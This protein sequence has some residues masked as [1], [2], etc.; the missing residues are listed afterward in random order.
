MDFKT[1]RN[2]EKLVDASMD[3]RVP[4][5]SRDGLEMRVRLMK[6]LKAFEAYSESDLHGFTYEEL[7]SEPSLKAFTGPQ[8]KRLMHFVSRRRA[9]FGPP[10][11]CSAITASVVVRAEKR[12][13]FDSVR[14]FLNI[15][16]V[17]GM[18]RDEYQRQSSAA[19]VAG[20]AFAM[21][22]TAG[23]AWAVGMAAGSRSSSDVPRDLE[24]DTA[25]EDTEMQ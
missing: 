1:M 20:F 23:L 8:I 14:S 21:A 25:E 19:F 11:R 10:T 5:F 2:L 9:K 18:D 12:K 13:V 22:T 7:R 6:S 16:A 17:K 4:R 15:D 24:S 3:P